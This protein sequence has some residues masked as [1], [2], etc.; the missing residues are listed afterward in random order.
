MQQGRP[1]WLRMADDDNCPV[2]L[3]APELLEMPYYSLLEGPH[4][5][6]PGRATGTASR[7]P[8]V[9]SRIPFELYKGP[10]CP[11]SVVDLI[12]YGHDFYRQTKVPC[13]NGS[14]LLSSPLR[15]RLNCKRAFR[16]YLGAP[17]HLPAAE[18][19]ELYAGHPAA[20]PMAEHG[21]MTVA[22]EVNRLYH[23]RLTL[24]P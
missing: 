18:I 19:V 1:D 2:C 23:D 16:Y 9:P 8:S 3:S 4:A 24:R 20:K 5:F 17:R 6:A 12:D 22:D 21:M 11:L 10:R 13:E 14:G 15:A 7:I